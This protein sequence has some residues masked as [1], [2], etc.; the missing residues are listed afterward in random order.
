M[1]MHAPQVLHRATITASVTSAERTSR[2]SHRG[3]H[4][5]RFCMGTPRRYPLWSGIAI[6]NLY[7]W[8]GFLLKGNLVG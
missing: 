8:P 7:Y 3:Q 1:V 2:D 4:T 5:T 6:G